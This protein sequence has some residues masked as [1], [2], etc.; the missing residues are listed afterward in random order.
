MCCG[1][2][3]GWYT[4]L[5]S[6]EHIMGDRVSATT[7]EMNTAP[8]KVRANSRNSAPVRPPWNPIGVYTAARVMVMAMIG[9]TSSRAPMKAASSRDR[10]SR[11]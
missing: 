1:S 3:P 6:L 9:R 11:T 10:P 2:Q 4:G 7:P 8:A 5:S